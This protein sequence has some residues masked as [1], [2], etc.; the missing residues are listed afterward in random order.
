M[1]TSWL[2]HWHTPEIPQS[3][4][5]LLSAFFQESYLYIYEV[6][7]NKFWSHYILDPLDHASLICYG[8]ISLKLVKD[9][10][11]DNILSISVSFHCL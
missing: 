3:L 7:V 1:A 10:Y 11:L 2:C 4:P 5:L 9:I 8:D 6:K